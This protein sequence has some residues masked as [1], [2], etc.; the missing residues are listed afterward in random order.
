MV[1]PEVE[2]QLKQL[3]IENIVLMGIEVC[4]IVVTKNSTI[5]FSYLSVPLQSEEKKAFGLIKFEC[6]HSILNS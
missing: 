6:W 5:K 1:I 2:E 4:S 3:N